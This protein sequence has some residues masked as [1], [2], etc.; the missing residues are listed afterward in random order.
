MVDYVEQCRVDNQNKRQ[1]DFNSRKDKISN[2]LISYTNAIKSISEI[3]QTLNAV[4]NMSQIEFLRTFDNEYLTQNISS[5]SVPKVHKEKYEK[6]NKSVILKDIYSRLS[7]LAD[8]KNEQLVTPKL[9]ESSL[10]SNRN[11]HS[12]ITMSGSASTNK[13]SS[14][15]FK[16]SHNSNQDYKRSFMWVNNDISSP[17][18]KI[19]NNDFNQNLRPRTQNNE[20]QVYGSLATSIK[21]GF[22]REK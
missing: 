5:I 6:V 15:W 16:K 11:K 18:L 20:E 22:R 19:T 14:K 3:D 8:D 2:C 4:V 1:I 9:F 17:N 7:L 13:K 21:G 10:N 12:K